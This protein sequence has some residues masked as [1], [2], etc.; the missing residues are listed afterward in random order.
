MINFI[1]GK[2]IDGNIYIEGD[3]SGLYTVTNQNDFDNFPLKKGLVKKKI[4]NPKYTELQDSY[5]TK[6]LCYCKGVGKTVSTIIDLD[7][8]TEKKIK[9]LRPAPHKMRYAEDRKKAIEIEFDEVG[10]ENVIVEDGFMAMKHFGE[11]KTEMKKRKDKERLEAR[12]NK[13]VKEIIKT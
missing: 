8:E 4:T 12:T 11:T 7:S 5:D 6:K 1:V 9:E 2:E 13:E 10:K 3:F